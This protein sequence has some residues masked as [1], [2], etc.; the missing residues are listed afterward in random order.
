MSDDVKNDG[1]PA[2]PG[3]YKTNTGLPFWSEG[4]SLRDYFA[5]LAMQGM[6][7][8]SALD[9]AGENGFYVV[10]SAYRMSDAMIQHREKK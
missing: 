8:N 3:A 10:K 6:L 9:L 4:M 7:A 2:F 5:G 1:G